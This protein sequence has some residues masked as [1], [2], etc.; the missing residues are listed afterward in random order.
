[1]LLLFLDVKL[2]LVALLCGPFLA[3]ATNWFRKESAKSYRVT[4][5]KV[6]LVIVHFVES[7]NGIRAVQAFR[8]EPRNQEIFD[9]VNDQ[10]RAANLVAFRLVAWFMPEI[11]LIGNVTIAVVLIYGGYLAFDGQVTVGVLAAFLLYLRQFFEPM[12]D[13]SQF[14]NTF[15]SANA[16]LEKISGVLEEEPGV[17]EPIHPVALTDARGDVR[18]DHVRLRV[19]RR[20]IRAARPRPRRSR[21]ARPSP[22]SAPPAP[23]RPRSPSS[24][25]GSTTPVDGAVTLDGVDLRSLDR[26]RPAPVGGDGHPGELPV[27]R[28]DLRQHPLRPPRGDPGARS[29]RR[30]ERS[31]PTASSRRCRRATTP[32]SPTAAA[33]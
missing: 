27:L 10:Y 7:M 18:F 11:R 3:W 22:W 17:P 29:R 24:R 2:G 9:D 23:A 33:C 31:A 14:Y 4:R 20:R 25:P 19:R 12:M 28:H 26:R 21:P 32:T 15:Q 13:I 30:P 1:M 8:R 16:A 6:A 5:E